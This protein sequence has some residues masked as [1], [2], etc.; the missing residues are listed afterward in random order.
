V[1]WYTIIDDDDIF[2]DGIS[3]VCVRY[4]DHMDC[5][6]CNMRAADYNSMYTPHII[7]GI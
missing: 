7:L 6:N 5:V 4:I 3:R 1:R 2:G